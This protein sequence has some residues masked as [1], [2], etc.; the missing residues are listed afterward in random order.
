MGL[1]RNALSMA[2]D[3][4]LGGREDEA[5][6]LRERALRD[7]LHRLSRQVAQLEARLRRLEPQPDGRFH[8]DMTIAEVRDAHEDADTVLAR[9]HLGGC[10][11]CAVSSVETLGEGAKLHQ[12]DL[13][14]LLADLNRL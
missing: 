3:S 4:V 13:D 10:A 5:A 6:Q 9:Y 1:V 11:S 12:I 14:G 7:D 2:K 8:P